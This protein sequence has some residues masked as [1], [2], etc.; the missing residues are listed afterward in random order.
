[1]KDADLFS[2]DTEKQTSR[3]RFNKAEEISIGPE[4]GLLH[5]RRDKRKTGGPFQ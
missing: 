3:K 2:V 4:A 5:Y 1:M